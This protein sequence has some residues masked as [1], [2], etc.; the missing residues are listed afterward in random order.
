MAG[1][2]AVGIVVAEKDFDWGLIEGVGDSK[3]VSPKNREAI[4]RQAQRLKKEKKINYIVIQKTA[5]QIDRKGI[6]VVI[7]DAIHS[8]LQKL[9]VPI[10][11]T[12]L[13]DGSLTAPET[14]K[15]QQTIIKGD[16]KEKAIGLA[17][18]MAKVTRDRHMVRVSKQYPL[19]EFDMHKGYGT[20]KHRKCIKKLGP[21]EKIH[22]FTYISR[23]V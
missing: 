4:F 22:R 21:V 23:I 15:N 1:P 11:S 10:H 5:L 8:G 20:E 7:Q 6:A 12:I 17:S 14:Y 16:T 3:Q 13:L 18:I 9:K 19:Y 2:V